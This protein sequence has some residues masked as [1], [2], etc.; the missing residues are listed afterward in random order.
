MLLTSTLSPSGLS[1]HEMFILYLPLQAQGKK[2][3]NTHRCLSKSIMRRLYSLPQH[4]GSE[5][6]NS[7]VV[8]TPQNKV[9]GNQEG[10]KVKK[11]LKNKYVTEW[12]T[13]TRERDKENFDLKI[14]ILTLT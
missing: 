8:A 10:L 7:R 4:T 2:K 13:L 9:T 1:Q 14:A 11:K 5:L 6:S 12:R 3:L